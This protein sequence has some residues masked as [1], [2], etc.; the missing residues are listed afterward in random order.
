MLGLIKTTSWLIGYVNILVGF[1][2]TNLRSLQLQNSRRRGG[3]VLAT[4][5][6]Q[7]HLQTVFTASGAEVLRQF[8]G[9]M[10]LHM[11]ADATSRK[12]RE[13]ERRKEN[14]E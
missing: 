9:S 14:G 5:K 10:S 8:S 6:W 11:Q 13:E 7:I 2:A 4:L 1:Y 3:G 12:E